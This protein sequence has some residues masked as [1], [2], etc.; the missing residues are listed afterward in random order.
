LSS[1]KSSAQRPVE[2]CT[3]TMTRSSPDAQSGTTSMA[4]TS[5]RGVSNS[6]SVG[7]IG[8]P[9]PGSLSLFVV[10]SAAT[11]LIRPGVCISKD[12]PRGMLHN[13]W[14]S[15][16]RMFR[17]CNPGAIPASDSTLVILTLGAS[18]SGKMSMPAPSP[19]SS[20]RNTSAATTV[21]G[22]GLSTRTSNRRA[23]LHSP[24]TDRKRT[25]PLYSP[26]CGNNAVSP[27]FSSACTG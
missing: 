27:V 11:M 1:T 3:L 15:C 20:S 14:A 23:I 12:A 4:C 8:E 13:P 16:T 5:S 25:P 2:S 7:F 17:W 10:H 19:G 26:G 24:F 21:T 6:P 9:S 22:A 18:A